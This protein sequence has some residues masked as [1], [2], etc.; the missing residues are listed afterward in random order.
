M[1]PLAGGGYTAEISERGAALRVLRHGERDLV[2]S[3]PEGG[4]IPYYAG[5]I[6]APWPG[7]IA[8]G[9]YAFDGREHQLTI[10]E[11]ERGHALHGLVADAGW[12]VVEWLAA[13]D[14]HAFVRL[15]HALTPA[16]GYPFRLDLQVT[17]RL[18]ARGL[19]TTVT[20][21]NAGAAPAPYGCG[22]HPWLLADADMLHVP[23][24]EL[25]VT[26]ERMIPGAPKS[27]AGTPLDF[28]TARP[29]GGLTVDHTYTG[30][31]E[32]EVRVGGTRLT[33]DPAVL[34]WVQVCTGAQFGYE[35]VAVEPMTCPP[36][37]FNSGAGL[38]VLQPGE[39]HEASWTIG[40]V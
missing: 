4:P 15:A 14:D 17:Y 7:R 11:P 16:P 22:P 26:D 36:D 3:W 25:L 5:T 8:G 13:E 10:S 6:L 28:R 21:V 35:G 12:R 40:A 24:A 31:A 32:G 38:V 18:D 27:V 30:L 2:T 39:R 20:A 33:W 19:T 23:A 29:I 34:P 37:A 9:A 1:P